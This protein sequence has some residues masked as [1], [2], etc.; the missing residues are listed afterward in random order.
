M[1]ALLIPLGS[2]AF[3]TGLLAGGNAAVALDKDFAAIVDTATY[4]VFLT[5][6]DRNSG[7]YVTNRTA[8]GFTVAAEKAGT[9]GTFS[10][11]VVAKRK[12]I[13]AGRLARAD[14]PK[15]LTIDPTSFPKAVTVAP[16][17]KP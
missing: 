1:G 14:V 5:E 11:R 4:H 7:L 16:P 17:K 3:G 12:D 9:S 6:Y 13:E 15:A 10:W 2:R 8:G